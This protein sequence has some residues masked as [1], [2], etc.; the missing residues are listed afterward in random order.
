MTSASRFHHAAPQ[1]KLSNFIRV[2]SRKTAPVLLLSLFFLGRQPVACGQ[3]VGVGDTQ[4]V[5]IPGVGHDYT[6]STANMLTE[7]V[8][9][10]DGSL[11]VSMKVPTPQGRAL[12]LPFSFRYSSNGTS[13][14]FL[15]TGVGNYPQAHVNWLD[16]T[17]DLS[18]GGWS[19]G[20]PK[21]STVFI[22]QWA[23]PPAV[24]GSPGTPYCDYFTS[25][26]FEDPTGGR[27]DLQISSAP[28]PQQCTYVVPRPTTYATGGDDLYKASTTQLSSYDATSPMPVTVAAADGTM[29]YFSIAG[30]IIKMD[31]T[32][33]ASTI[34]ACPIMRKTPTEIELLLA[35][36]LATGRP[37]A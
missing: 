15:A 11:T 4:V 30:G 36:P 7:T 27:H 3:L 31:T 32:P 13:H 10:V 14:P 16:N 8:S 37:A 23:G 20:L 19:Y 29:Y 22:Q 35:K 9:P 24:P 25:Y 12:S 21:L 5:P 6:G 1:C 17:S 18:K 2:I 26:I 28:A 33:L 34:A